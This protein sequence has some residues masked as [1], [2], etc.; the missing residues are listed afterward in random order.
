M[1]SYIANG[2]A[3]PLTSSSGLKSRDS[4]YFDQ[5]LHSRGDNVVRRAETPEKRYIDSYLKRG[6]GDSHKARHMHK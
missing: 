1:N 5:L 3:T 2:G 4:P 6:L